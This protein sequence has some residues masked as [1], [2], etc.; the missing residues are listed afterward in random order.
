M[1]N[2]DCLKSRCT[3][4]SFKFFVDSTKKDRSAF[5]VSSFSFE[6]CILSYCSIEED[7]RDVSLPYVKTYNDGYRYLLHM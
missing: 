2:S 1:E 7:S 5:E 3:Q 4:K 6:Q